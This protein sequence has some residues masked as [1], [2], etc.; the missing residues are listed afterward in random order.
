[1]PLKPT[2]RL[3]RIIGLRRTTGAG[4]VN[5]PPGALFY[6]STRWEYQRGYRDKICPRCSVRARYEGIVMVTGLS[7]ASRTEQSLVNYYTA[8]SAHLDSSRAGPR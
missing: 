5:P 3:S 8:A 6:P 7:D 1:V 2:F 4:G